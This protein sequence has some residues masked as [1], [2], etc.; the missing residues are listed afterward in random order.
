MTP[1]TKRPLHV[2]NNTYAGSSNINT[3]HNAR[4]YVLLPFYGKN[5]PVLNHGTC[6]MSLL[7]RTKCY[8]ESLTLTLP[9]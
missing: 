9:L 8:K 1:I 2:R 3:H 5:E 6:L 7:Q 4:V